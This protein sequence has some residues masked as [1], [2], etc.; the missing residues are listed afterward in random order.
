M[1]KLFVLVLSVLLIC[2]CSAIVSAAGTKYNTAGDLYQSWGED[3]PDYIC[4]MWSTDGSFDNLTFGI[5]NNAA[6]NAG[7][8][9]ILDL[10]ENDAT[11]TFVYQVFSRNYLLQ[12]QEEIYE[13]FQK[14]LGLVST[15]LD[16]IKNCIT[17]GILDERKADADTQNMIRE[18]T[19]KYGEAVCVEYTGEIY[20]MTTKTAYTQAFP[21]L[22]TGIAMICLVSTAL[23]VAQRKRM[24][25]L[26]SNNGTTVSATAPHSVKAVEDMIS[27]SNYAV[28]ADLDQKVRE[29][30]KK[31]RKQSV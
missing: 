21:V 12:I 29:F 26:Q 20:P 11:L 28:T 23:V 27:K 15:G 31:N 16:E 7:K 19:R 13:Y 18:I 14:D 5:Q 1:K 2:T 17:L 6:G 22:A 30:I 9:E 4:G 3:I 8:Q 25:L 10:V 24:L